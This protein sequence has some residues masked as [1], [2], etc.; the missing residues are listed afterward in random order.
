[1]STERMRAASGEGKPDTGPS[2]LDLKSESIV[3]RGAPFTAQKSSLICVVLP[4]PNSLPFFMFPYFCLTGKYS[5]SA[6][7]QPP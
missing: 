5:H 4:G 3:G 6:D 1:M 7:I 2:V